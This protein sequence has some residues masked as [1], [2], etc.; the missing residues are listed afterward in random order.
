MKDNLP[1][2]RRVFHPTPQK[3]G[4]FYSLPA[5]EQAGYSA[6]HRLPVSIRF[7]LES[8]LRNYD[9]TQVTREHVETLA[10][11]T[12]ADDR[13]EVPLTVGR[14]ILQDFTGTPLV[15]DLAAMPLRR[16]TLGQGA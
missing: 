4:E 5:L 14:V 9:G 12:P 2:T 16:C 1:D 13:V 3:S 6:I 11:W 15:C 8:V 10:C 7:L